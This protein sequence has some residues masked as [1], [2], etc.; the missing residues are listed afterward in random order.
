MDGSYREPRPVRIQVLMLASQVPV[1]NYNCL[2]TITQEMTRCGFNSLTHGT[3]P[4]MIDEP[5]HLL[6]Q[7]CRQA[8]EE[9]FIRIEEN[10]IPLTLDHHHYGY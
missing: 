8:V 3:H 4:V 7:A 6:P 1:T 9:K 10:D 2:V 5:L